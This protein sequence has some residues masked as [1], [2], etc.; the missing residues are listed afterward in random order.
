MSRGRRSRFE[1]NLAE[2]LETDFG[3]KCAHEWM[4]LIRGLLMLVKRTHIVWILAIA[5]AQ[6]Q[7][8]DVYN[9]YF[10][11]APGPQTV[12]QGGAATAPAATAAPSPLEPEPSVA[13]STPVAT[14]APAATMTPEINKDSRRRRF[15]VGLGVANVFDNFSYG[16]EDVNGRYALMAEYSFN[17]YLTADMSLK[18]DSFSGEWSK[19]GESI[20][21]S[22]VPTL[23][24]NVFPFHLN[25][26]GSEVLALGFQGG[27]GYG[28]FDNRE[29][30]GYVTDEFGE[31][32]SRSKHEMVLRGYLGIVT[33]INFPSDFAL[34]IQGRSFR[35]GFAE[36]VVTLN[37]MF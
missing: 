15:S 22:M 37:Y 29:V 16:T 24:L 31:I 28:A 1:A 32:L 8:D 13:P 35:G 12:I 33:Q 26:F 17:K 34:R 20:F 27:I 18:L 30:I 4:Q 6:A 7:A 3:T 14:T 19:T 9:F 11:K 2:L 25:F 23:G 10:Q 36:S 21:K 5:V